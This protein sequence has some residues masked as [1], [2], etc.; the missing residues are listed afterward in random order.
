[1]LIFGREGGRIGVC[2][3]C[4]YLVCLS[5]LFEVLDVGLFVGFV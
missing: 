3:V 1:M 4:C 2:L 5:G